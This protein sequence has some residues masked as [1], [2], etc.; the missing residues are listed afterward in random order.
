MCALQKKPSFPLQLSTTGKTTEWYRQ[1]AGSQGGRP[2]SG[3]FPQLGVFHVVQQGTCQPLRL[4]FAKLIKAMNMNSTIE[5]K[6]IQS[7]PIDTESAE[8]VRARRV[9]NAH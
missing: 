1:A 9:N 7:N 6:S 2:V 3:R 5:I 8:W 4:H